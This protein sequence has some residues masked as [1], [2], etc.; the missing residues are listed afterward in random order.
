[1]IRSFRGKDAERLFQREPVR[2]FKAIEPVARRKLEMIEAAQSLEDLRNPP[3]RT[4][5]PS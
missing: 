3:V 5:W 2:R 4:A 1:M